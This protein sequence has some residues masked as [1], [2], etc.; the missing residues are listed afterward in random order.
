MSGDSTSIEK[1]MIEEM[2]QNRM[3]CLE[4]SNKLASL[5]TSVKS[6]M[7]DTREERTRVSD[8]RKRLDDIG[9]DVEKIKAKAALIGTVAGF[10]AALFVALASAFFRYMLK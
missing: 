3:I 1:I 7:T 6:L 4:I 5:E 9:L 10:V 8:L 2:R